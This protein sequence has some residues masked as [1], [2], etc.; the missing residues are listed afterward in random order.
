MT[1]RASSTP[2]SNTPAPEPLLQA[3]ERRAPRK[4]VAHALALIARMYGG[5]PQEAAAAEADLAVW[6]QAS[7]G[8]AHAASTAQRIWNVTDASGLRAT[9]AAPPTAAQARRGRRQVIGLLG[10]TGVLA[11]LGAG[12][13]WLWLQPTFELAL[14]TGRAQA[15]SQDLPDGSELDLAAHTAVQIRFFRDH[16]VVQ[17]AQ[18]EARFHVAPDSQRPFLVDTPWGRV[19]VLGTVFTVSARDGRMR[20]EVVQG[21]VAV[22]AGAPAPRA[23][24]GGDLPSVE[25]VRGDMVEAGQH[26]L[27]P[28][29]HID[30]ADVGAWKQG[31]LVFR[32]TRLPDLVARWNDYLAT[33]LSLAADPELR[34]LRVTG[35]YAVRDPQAF[36]DAL[37]LALPLRAERTGAG[38]VVLALRK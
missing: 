18:G 31:W 13:R 37:T 29:G 38:T 9:R 7:V 17:L 20:V 30:P 1:L 33:P 35:R 25:L 34:D 36:V 32:N 4:L 8:N 12:T 15:L 28:R 21:R 24:D 5:T 23:L 22:W 26:G 3:D 27:G 2:H 14:R 16:R 6:R 19:R 10:I 11:S